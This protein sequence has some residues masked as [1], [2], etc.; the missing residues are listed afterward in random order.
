MLKRTAIEQAVDLLRMPSLAVSMRRFSLP[1]D[2]SLMLRV[3]ARL[4]E[5]EAEAMR[6]TGEPLAMLGEAAEFYVIQIMF[7]SQSDS[8]RIL[9]VHPDASR[10]EIWV[11]M[12]ALLRWLHPDVNSGETRG[13][14]ATKVLRAWDGVKTPER[15]ALTNQSIARA[16]L[17]DRPRRVSE[18]EVSTRRQRAVAWAQ[19]RRI[20]R[21]DKRRRLHK[22]ARI[23]LVAGLCGAAVVG[24][25]SFA[26]GED[27]APQILTIPAL[28]WSEVKPSGAAGSDSR[29]TSLRSECERPREGVDCAERSHDCC[30][31]RGPAEPLGR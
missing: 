25:L 19:P 26:S 17:A 5:A 9:G 1:P 30:L 18:S 28:L 15:R 21:R 16:A 27:I 23:G 7:H 20:D 13:V 6:L 22:A 11:N 2:V 8:Y 24:Y 12:A 3:L 14:L 10:E 31:P 29:Q 4:P